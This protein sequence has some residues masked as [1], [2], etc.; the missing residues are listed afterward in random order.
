MSIEIY[1]PE[2]KKIVND[3]DIVSK[4]GMV[5]PVTIDLVAGDTI[6]FNDLT[7]LIHLSAK[8]SKTN[9]LATLP[10]EDITIFISQVFS[11]QRREREVI[12]QTPAQKDEWNDLIVECGGTV[13]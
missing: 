1:S 4:S 10:A 5:L 7:I 13:Q 6:V 12:K 2:V 3:Y 8:P 11:V 9:P